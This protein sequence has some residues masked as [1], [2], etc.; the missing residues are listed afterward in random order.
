[1]NP[2][3]PTEPAAPMNPSA[4]LDTTDNPTASPADYTPLLILGAIV[5]MVLL[6]PTKGRR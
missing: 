5:A 6:S 2:T 4:P 1:M 3:N